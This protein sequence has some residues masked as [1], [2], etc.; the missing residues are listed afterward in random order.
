[1]SEGVEDGRL[2]I[3]EGAEVGAAP[4]LPDGE[5]TE[6]EAVVLKTGSGL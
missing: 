3:P 6:G 4:D 5:Q 2:E 1:M